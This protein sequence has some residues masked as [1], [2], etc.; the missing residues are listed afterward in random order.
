MEHPSTGKRTV[1]WTNYGSYRLIDISTSG[2][3]YEPNNAEQI[4]AIP[5]TWALA[6]RFIICFLG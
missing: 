6:G 1:H 4:R 2:A 5:T 3:F